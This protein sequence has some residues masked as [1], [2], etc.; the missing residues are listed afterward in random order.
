[1]EIRPPDVRMVRVVHAFTGR[2]LF[3]ATHPRLGQVRVFVLKEWTWDKLRGTLPEGFSKFNVELIHNNRRLDAFRELMS[4]TNEDCLEIGYVIKELRAPGPRALRD[5][6][7]AI[8][9]FQAVSTIIYL[10][11]KLLRWSEY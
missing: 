6:T 10:G 1:M 2:I 9:R 7:E 5:M 4:L 3:E 11:M 8:S